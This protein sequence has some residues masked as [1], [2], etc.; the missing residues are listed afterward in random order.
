MSKLLAMMMKPKNYM[1]ATIKGSLTDND[2]VFSGFSASNYLKIQEPFTINSNTVIEIQTKIN[3]TTNTLLSDILGTPNN[4]YLQL[5]SGSESKLRFYLGNGSSWSIL[6][7]QAGITEIQANTDYYIRL[8]INNN[9]VKLLLSI[10]NTNWITEFDVN[11][12]ITEQ[13][14][15]NITIGRGRTTG[16][17]LRGS[18]DINQSYIKI[19]NTKYQLQAV[20][21]YTVVGNP[22][23]TDGVVSGFSGSDY[24]TAPKI[25]FSNIDSWEIKIAFQVNS[26]NGD[27]EQI[28]ENASTTA[29][30]HIYYT[31]INN[32]NRVYCQFSNSN[33]VI[34]ATRFNISFGTKYYIKAKFTGIKYVLQY[35]T[36]N[37]NWITFGELNSTEKIA[38]AT[39]LSCFGYSVRFSSR[40]LDGSIDLNETYIKI[41]GKL[42]FNGQPA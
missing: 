15:Y 10:D 32:E 41:D 4:Y 21:G 26:D 5:I 24:L 23:I 33:G 8:L 13:Y 28:F 30:F 6:N 36:D 20:V 12:S 34:L 31:Y 19:A 18:L 1:Y 38:T 7:A 17:Y 29:G 39:T 3:L 22:T 14:I 9:N 42:W 40:A 25:D 11:V 37:M 16:Q 35:S 27:Y 2:G